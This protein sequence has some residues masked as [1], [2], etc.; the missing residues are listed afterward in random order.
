MASWSL[1]TAYTPC[2]R[3]KPGSNGVIPAIET[4]NGGVRLRR[5]ISAPTSPTGTAAANDATTGLKPH[6]CARGTG[7]AR[8]STDRRGHQ[9]PPLG[10][11]GQGEGSRSC[12]AEHDADS[13]FPQ[14]RGRVRA[15]R[16]VGAPNFV[17]TWR[18]NATPA[19]VA[20]VS[21][22]SSKNRATAVTAAPVITS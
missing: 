9:C 17:A 11:A 16:Q 14:R 22:T 8:C 18:T 12:R 2:S 21:M 20:A 3:A 4:I 10:I 7:D 6:V 15:D 5:S 13:Q 1:R 19:I